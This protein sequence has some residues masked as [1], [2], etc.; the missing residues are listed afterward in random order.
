ML[1]QQELA[2]FL[3]YL[4][5]P[6][7]LRGRLFWINEASTS[8]HLNLKVKIEI[9]NHPK[10]AINALWA[11]WGNGVMAN[12]AESYHCFVPRCRDHSKEKR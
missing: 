3:F 6:Q 12:G 5:K 10:V 1:L 7:T 8:L 2:L 4:S 11:R 9:G